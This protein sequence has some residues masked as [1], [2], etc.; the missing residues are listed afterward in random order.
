MLGVLILFSFDVRSTGA[1][2]AEVDLALVLAVDIS[3]SV[4]SIEY[5]LQR[6]G[7]A[8]AI[9]HPDVIAAIKKGPLKKIAV[10]VVQWSDYESQVVVVPWVV[11]RDAKS[12]IGFSKRVERAVRFYGGYGTHVA[13]VIE[14]GGNLLEDVPFIAHR[15]VIDISGDGHDNITKAPGRHRDQAVAAGITINGLAIE[16]EDKNLRLYYR[17]FVIGGPGAFVVRVQRYEDFADAMKKKLIREISPKALT[18]DQTP[19]NPG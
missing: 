15:K 3:R 8:Y 13:G 11:I 18:S 19:F 4:N 16:N 9:R 7:L 10:T 5:E 12:A 14:F 1:N 2:G 6:S 17:D